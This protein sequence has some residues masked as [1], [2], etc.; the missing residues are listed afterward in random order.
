MNRK[1]TPEMDDWLRA[2]YAGTPNAPLL[3]AFAAEFGWRPT[4]AAL[5]TRASG[6][7]LRKPRKEWA[8]EEVEWFVAFVPGH[9]EYEISAEHERLFGEPLTEGQ[10]GNAK[11]RHGV[12]SGTHGGR[13]QKGQASWNKGMRQCDFMS[14]EAIERTKATRFMKGEVRDRPDGRIKPIG[15]ERAGATGGYVWV[16]VM[17]SRTDGIQPQ[18]PGNFNRNYRL[19]HH[20]VWE[21]HNGPVPPHTMIVFADHDKRNFDP[22]NLVAVP[23]RLWCRIS[24]LGMQYCDRESLEACMARASLHAAMADKRREL[25]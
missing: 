19:K 22:D 7:G 24:Q 16:K 13:F 14:A 5:A 4:M 20:V 10:I 15:R 12:R 11:M 23:R 17:D 25:A 1:W 2:R 3:D 21:E 8:E 9:T 18:V 6:L